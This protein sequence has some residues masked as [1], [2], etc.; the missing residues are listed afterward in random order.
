MR[1]ITWKLSACKEETKRLE[2]ELDHANIL[3][4]HGR[5]SEGYKNDIIQSQKE[6]LDYKDEINDKLRGQLEEL[7]LIR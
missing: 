1:I 7:K 3:L 2:K 6:L 5:E 4:R